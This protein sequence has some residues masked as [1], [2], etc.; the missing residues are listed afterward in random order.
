MKQFFLVTMI[1]LGVGCISL[2][3][4][5]QGADAVLKKVA[6]AMEKPSSP[7]PDYDSPIKLK[8]ELKAFREKGNSLNPAEIAK[9]WLQFVDRFLN[10]P[11]ERGSTSW[12][13]SSSNDPEGNVIGFQQVAEAMPAP[14]SWDALAQQ[15]DARTP[16]KND[17]A[18][19]VVLRVMAHWLAGNTA[20]LKKDIDELEQ[21]PKQQTSYQLNTLRWGLIQN[22]DDGAAVLSFLE[23][24]VEKDAK[25]ADRG[26]VLQLPDLVSLVGE[27]R[28]AKFLRQALRDEKGEISIERG[29]AT[30][31]LARKLAVEMVND[32]KGAQ[33]GLAT[34]LDATA[35][36]EGMAKR[37]PETDRNSYRR[38][39]AQSYYL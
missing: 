18:R 7:T 24:R 23:Q 26:L 25:T 11:A 2:A 9:Q 16:E 13:S 6:A 35:L 36:Y 37:F 38:A 14:L 33:W 17:I 4:D 31:K 39:Q 22:S 1:F 21:Q 15:L 8:K 28:A 29:V 12:S 34:S 5:Y 32:L 27:E 20:A 10:L 19:T 3:E 30:Q